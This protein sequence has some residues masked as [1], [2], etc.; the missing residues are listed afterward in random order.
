MKK[1]IIKQEKLY[2]ESLFLKTRIND[3]KDENTKLKARIST[4]DVLFICP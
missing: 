3:L 4:Q 1:K 2:E